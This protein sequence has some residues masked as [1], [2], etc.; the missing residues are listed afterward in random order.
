MN[1]C[2]QHTARLISKFT[3]GLLCFIL[4]LSLFCPI[5]AKVAE[6]EQKTVR[7]GYYVN[8]HFQEGTS[9]DDV[10]SGYGYEYLRKVAY[11]SGWKY[12]YVYGKWADLYEMFLDGE[13]DIMAGIFKLDERED[14]ILYP[15]YEMGIEN[16]YLYRHEGDTE[17]VGKDI[18]TLSGK[19]IGVIKNT[20]ME[21]SLHKW[22]SE[23]SVDAEIVEFVGYEEEQAAFDR[24]EI[25]VF[26]EMDFNIS[27]DS[28]RAAVVKIG[29]LPYYLAVT[30]KRPDL[31]RELNSALEKLN[32]VEPYFRQNLQYSNYGNSLISH[33]L[34]ETEQE[35]VRKH[36]VINVGYFE[37]YMP[38]CGSDKNGNA[39]G[40]LI[41]V[42]DE[43][44]RKLSIEKNISVRYV[45]YQSYEEMIA[46]LHTGKL[47]V[48]FPVDGELWNAE[49]DGIFSS[50]TVVSAGVDLVFEGSY[51]DKTVA[52]I[53]VNKNN[54]LQYYYTVSNFPMQISCSVIQ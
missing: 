41:D 47:D 40:L 46:E 16:Y 1:I 17:I 7:V 48:V 10:K 11:Y 18:S 5:T 6:T 12:E 13:I 29:D 52:S 37:T 28:G 44:L 26:V 42:M 49:K 14:H 43:I 24:K 15:D 45:P 32:E 3:A 30:K 39:T 54:K 53:A 2:K 51:D 20:T 34:S 23:N 25:D 8:E 27:T 36:D 21:D 31:L 4:V 22:L 19:K 35:W 38:Y 33:T 50:S 9:E